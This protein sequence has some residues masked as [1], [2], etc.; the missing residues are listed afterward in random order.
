MLQHHQALLE[1]VEA[2]NVPGLHN[3]RRRDF[4]S[5]KDKKLPPPQGLL[6]ENDGD[7]AAEEIALIILTPR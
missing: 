2:F 5:V 7:I 6:H 1:R 3:R 4:T